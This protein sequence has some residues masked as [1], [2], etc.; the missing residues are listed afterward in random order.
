MGLRKDLDRKGV[1]YLYLLKDGEVVL[2]VGTASNPKSRFNSH[3]KRSKTENAL[4]YQYVRKNNI[5]L[6][7][8]VVK[9]LIGTYADAEKEEIKLIKHYQSTCLN[10]YNNPNKKHYYEIEKR[11]S[12]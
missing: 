10:F 4:I 11:L 5:V 2:Y 9:K 8:V 1:R 3:L 7:M 12:L 6:K